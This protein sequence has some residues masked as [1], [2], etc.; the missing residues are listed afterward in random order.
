MS[1]VSKQTL[2]ILGAFDRLNY[3]DIL[4]PVVIDY[5]LK[6]SSLVMPFESYGTKRSDLSHFG[7]GVSLSLR[8]LL[9][10]TRDDIET[11]LIVAGGE[12]L[13]ATWSTVYSY[14]VPKYNEVLLRGLRRVL[15]TNMIDFLVRKAA[16]ADIM[17]PFILGRKDFR[18]PTRVF[19]NAVG[20][21]ALAQMRR[22]KLIRIGEKLAEASYISVRDFT[23]KNVLDSLDLPIKIELAPDSAA[24]ISDIY[25]LEKLEPFI[26]NVIRKF[27]DDNQQG[28]IC[29]QSGRYSAYGREKVIAEQLSE[30]GR[31]TGLPIVLLTIGHAVGH[32]D[33]VAIEKIRRYFPA[34]IAAVAPT[35]LNIFDIMAA[36]SHASVF[37]GTSLHGAITAISYGIPY[38]AI[39]SNVPKLQEYLNTWYPL[40]ASHPYDF[41]NLNA[42]IEEA[43]QSDLIELRKCRER[44]IRLAYQNFR[45]MFDIAFP[46][47]KAKDTGNIKSDNSG[48]F[49][50]GLK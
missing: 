6:K 14:L 35:I 48:S 26:S 47:T 17:S 12:I 50:S 20:G 43:M 15:G 36:I 45:N 19:Y 33:R 10:A 37:A 7:G 25:P 46:D 29:F 21:S 18:T 5:A 22:S 49:A 24:I 27:L 11:I 41:E 32:E 38:A 44:M 9:A 8:D 2:A 3:G 23:T 40:A 39:C 4:F 1:T 31:R 42:T 30:I 28:Y 34:K 13:D 16:R